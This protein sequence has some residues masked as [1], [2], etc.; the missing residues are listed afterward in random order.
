MDSALTSKIFT[1]TLSLFSDKRRSSVLMFA[2]LAGSERVENLRAVGT[3]MKEAK[4]INQSLLSLR[5]VLRDQRKKVRLDF[6][7]KLFTNQFQQTDGMKMWCILN[8]VNS[9]V[10]KDL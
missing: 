9:P 4:H 10:M 5:S 7:Y 3:R 6:F 2:D 8:D 1:F